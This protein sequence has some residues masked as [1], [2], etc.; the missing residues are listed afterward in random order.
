MQDRIDLLN[1][2]LEDRGITNFTANEMGR[3]PNG[4]WDGPRF[5][6][7][8]ENDLPRILPT[9]TCIQRIRNYIGPTRLNSVYRPQA[10]TDIL[11]GRVSEDSQHGYFTAADYSAID[12]AVPFSEVVGVSTSVVEM[13]IFQADLH[14][15]RVPED[16]Q[17]YVGFF[18]YPG[19]EFCHLD[20]GTFRNAHII[21]RV[22]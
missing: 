18:I 5:L 9:M 14:N 10:Y 21:R 17:L 20:I 11:P 16:E 3:L 22:T 7:P 12:P 4:N 2:Y 8:E 1:E 19:S 6:L 13:A 15:V